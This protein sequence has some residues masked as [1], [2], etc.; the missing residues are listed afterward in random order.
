MQLPSACYFFRASYARIVARARVST[1]ASYA[2]LRPLV[3]TVSANALRDSTLLNKLQDYFD[4]KKLQSNP[5]RIV[6]MVT[7][8]ARAHSYY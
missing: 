1:R 4:Q 3:T 2:P 8:S 7:G 5:Y 6:K